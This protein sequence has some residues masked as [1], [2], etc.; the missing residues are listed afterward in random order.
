MALSE[1]DDFLATFIP[2]QVAAEQAIHHGDVEPRLA[3]WSRQ[4]PVTLFR[5]VGPLQERLG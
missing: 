1:P 3:L 5:G 4:D 2:R